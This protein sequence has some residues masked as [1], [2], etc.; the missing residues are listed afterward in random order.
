MKNEKILEMLNNGQIEDL[1]RKISEEI[2]TDSLKGKSGAGQRYK[3]MQ[4]FVKYNN[5]IES[6]RVLC[7]AKEIDGK[8]YFT[9]GHCLVATSEPVGNIETWTEAD[10]DWL[11]VD[12]IF[13]AQPNTDSF[14]VDFKRILAEGKSQGY[15]FAKENLHPSSGR[16]REYVCKIGNA[17]FNLALLDYAY[18]LIDDGNPAEAHHSGKSTDGIYVE[19]S[20]GKAMILPIRVDRDVDVHHLIEHELAA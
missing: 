6:R 3:A 10:E 9:D 7:K 4:R 8:F 1:K 13:K 2:Y 19:T 17:Y 20:V 11:K 15:K 16:V 18:S 14:K 12:S 5:P